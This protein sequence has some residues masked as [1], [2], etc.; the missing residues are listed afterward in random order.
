MI[1]LQDITKHKCEKYS[2]AQCLTRQIKY[3]SLEKL[4]STEMEIMNVHHKFLLLIIYELK[5]MPKSLRLDIKERVHFRFCSLKGLFKFDYK[6]LLKST[7]PGDQL[8][9]SSL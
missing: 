7:L 2:D 8:H 1:Y 3:H 6:Q 5:I 9:N 4:E